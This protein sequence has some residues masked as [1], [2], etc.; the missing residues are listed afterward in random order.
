MDKA[1]QLENETYGSQQ[2]S[3]NEIKDEETRSVSL[4]FFIYRLIVYAD[5]R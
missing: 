4:S 2:V 5:A 1:V 3:D